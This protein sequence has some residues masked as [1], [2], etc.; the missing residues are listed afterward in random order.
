MRIAR[1]LAGLLVVMGLAGWAI[2]G[3]PPN[4]QLAIT[5]DSVNYLRAAHDF[6]DGHGLDLF[7]FALFDPRYVAY[8]VWPPL[9][10]LLLSTGLP[11]LLIQAGLIA[12][13]A[14]FAYGLLVRL[15]RF[16]SPVAVVSALVVSLTW[17]LLVDASY[18]WSEPLAM[19]WLFAALLALSELAAGGP[20]EMRR[21]VM[22]WLLA[23]LA[24]TLAVYARYA[25][26]VF[27]PGLMLTLLRAPL[28]WRRRWFLIA[29]TPCVA[30]IFLAPLLLHNLIVTGHLSGG[31]RGASHMTLLMLL[32]S[33]VFY[34]G[35]I[36]GNDP[37]TRA[38]LVVCVLALVLTTV[39]Y[40][41]DRGRLPEK[42]NSD[43]D[44]GTQWLAWMASAMALAYL[45]GIVLL[46]AWKG[47]DWGT[48]I[49]SPAAPMILL[50][51]SAWAM[52]VWRGTPVIWQRVVLV[53]PFAGMLGLAGL[54]SWQMRADAWQNWRALGTPQWQMS[55]LGIYTNL[56]PVKSVPV[57]GIVLVARP[58]LIS[59]RTGWDC[60]YVPAGPWTHVELL[61]IAAAARA[62]MIENRQA[63]Q[64]AHALRG[65]VPDMRAYRVAG[66]AMV[67][68]GR[69]QPFEHG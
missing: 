13:L 22:Y 35:W 50:A 62:L 3:L 61:R 32:S 27:I 37:E 9:Y 51:V 42:T 40:L 47:F 63:E 44:G 15:G 34:T 38:A 58:G 45:L 12:G 55:P 20:Q 69:L 36:F 66:V 46:R 16:P 57:S 41:V 68:W 28:P 10:P 11:P 26:L 18:V 14:G 52:V 23:V 17:P 53:L 24:V 59:F 8:T 1:V 67:V 5:P 7:N 25:A 56:R 30:L 48:R 60:R 29:A 64:L 4:G 54:T 6:M 2:L 31:V 49:V 39:V 33:V 21:I 19:F 65:V 43:P